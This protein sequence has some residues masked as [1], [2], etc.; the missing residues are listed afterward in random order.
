MIAL[1]ISVDG[2]NTN[3]DSNGIIWV[4]FLAG[5]ATTTCVQLVCWCDDVQIHL[6]WQK[7]PLLSC[8]VPLVRR[9]EIWVRYRHL[10]WRA[11]YICSFL[12]D[13]LNCHD[14][15]LCRFF[16]CSSTV[17]ASLASAHAYILLLDGC[18]WWKWASFCFFVPLLCFY[19]RWWPLGLSN[20]RFVRVL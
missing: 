20:C 14:P 3:N 9:S 18:C 6:G 1:I 11:W 16:I 10:W 13:L 19:R 2:D 8:P 17:A 4:V 15:V 12:C 7:L 5:A